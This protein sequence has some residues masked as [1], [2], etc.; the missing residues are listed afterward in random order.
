MKLLKKIK[1]LK[2]LKMLIGVAVVFQ[3][4]KMT[5]I[6]NRRMKLKIYKINLSKK[7]KKFFF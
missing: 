3:I 7:K 4:N 2:C 5:E 1:L 6:N